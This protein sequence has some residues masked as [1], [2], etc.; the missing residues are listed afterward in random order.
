MIDEIA[1]DN[2][3]TQC[4]TIL[5]GSGSLAHDFE[6]EFQ[7]CNDNIDNHIDIAYNFLCVCGKAV[8]TGNSETLKNTF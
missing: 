5:V 4:L 1:G 8:F 2:S 6:F 7:N 3:S